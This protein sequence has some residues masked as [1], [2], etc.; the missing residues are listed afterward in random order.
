MDHHAHRNNSRHTTAHHNRSKPVG[1]PDSP[2][3]DAMNSNKTQ[4]HINNPNFYPINAQGAGS[5][6][7]DARWVRR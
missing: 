2:M 7:H 3:D 4:S 1:G 5:R 6:K